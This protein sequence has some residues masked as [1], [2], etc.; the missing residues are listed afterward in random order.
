MNHI[1]NRY[2]QFLMKSPLFFSI[3]TLFGQFFY[4]TSINDSLIIELNIFWIESAELFLNWIIFWIES[5]VKQYWIEYW[6][7]HFWAKF[8]HWIESDR[9]SPTPTSGSILRLTIAKWKHWAALNSLELLTFF[10]TFSHEKQIGC[11]S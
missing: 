5:W 4:M 8:K 6:M 11:I 7:N 3:W 1:S 2:L 9:V 10:I